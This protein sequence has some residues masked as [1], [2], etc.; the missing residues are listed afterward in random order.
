MNI[1][2][3]SDFG[4]LAMDVLCVVSLPEELSSKIED[5]CLNCHWHSHDIM[6]TP[7]FPVILK[8]T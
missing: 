1:A 2:L 3:A 6:L 4:L 8:L 7:C 5:S